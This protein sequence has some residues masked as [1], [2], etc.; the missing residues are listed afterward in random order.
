MLFKFG[1]ILS[2]NVYDDNRNRERQIV[3]NKE[4]N[5]KS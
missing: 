2:V 1:C 5:D 4:F 3:L